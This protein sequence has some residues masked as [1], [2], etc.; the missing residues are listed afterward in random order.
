MSSAR[1]DGPPLLDREEP[2][3]KTTVIIGGR[4]TTGNADGPAGSGLRK[5]VG[6]AA[7]GAVVLSTVVLTA[8]ADAAALPK[9]GAA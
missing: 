3:G 7:T 9:K 2:M 8:P 1:E 6:L 4:E 5:M